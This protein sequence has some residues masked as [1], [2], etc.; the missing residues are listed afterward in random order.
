MYIETMGKVLSQTLHENGDLAVIVP[1]PMNSKAKKLVDD[2]LLKWMKEA[3][4]L[5]RVGAVHV[6][7]PDMPTTKTL[8][9]RELRK[10]WERVLRDIGIFSPQVKRILV[11]GETKVLRVCVPGLGAEIGDAHGTIFKLEN[12]LEL[13]PTF[14]LKDWELKH[15][16]P[17][18]ERDILRLLKLTRPEAPLPYLNEITPG[19]K[20]R[21]VIDLETTG[22][23]HEDIIT[24]VGI[25]WSDTERAIY[26]NHESTKSLYEL[27]R[28]LPELADEFWFHNSQFDLSFMGAEF[29][30]RTFGKIHDTMIR[31]KSRGELVNSLKHL[32]NVYTARPGNYAW[33]VPGTEHRYDDPAYIAEDLDVTWRLAKIFDKDGSREVVKL[34]EEAAVMAC[35]QTIRGSAIDLPVLDNLVSEGRT[36]IDRAYPELCTKYGCN[37]NSNDE[38]IESLKDQGYSFVTYTKTGKESITT[39]VLEGQGLY[40]IVEYRKAQKLDS[41]FVAKIRSLIRKD[42]LLPHIQTM[43]GART[44]RSTMRDFNHQQAGRK[45]PVKKLL[46]SRFKN[47]KIAAVDLAQAEL[48]AACLLADDDVMAEWL[49]SVDAHRVNAANAFQVAFEEV[50]DDQRTAAKTVVF[51]LVYGGGAQTD[52][53]KRVEEYLRGKFKKLFKWLDSVGY[54][55]MRE[56]SVTDYWGKTCG[57]LDLLDYRGKGGVRRAGINS[58]IQGL[59]SHFAI[60]ITVRIWKL[61]RELGLQSLVLFGVHDS[62]VMDVHPDEEE[63]VTQ[64]VRQAFRDLLTMTSLQKLRL[65]GKLAIEG[66][67]QFGS[68]W[69]DTKNGEKILCSTLM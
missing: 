47:G 6:I 2:F 20:K 3:G 51:R 24:A 68:S 29:R 10:G 19:K 7:L 48:R 41:S 39:E 22:L 63:K 25:Q 5:N 36:Y 33:H 14:E 32:G 31:S 55:A 21:I 52:G 50:T 61:F 49:M 34:M 58:P 9:L 18:M 38:L 66:E 62:I 37:I 11:L 64:V 43:M 35:E 59:A 45:G 12:G 26:T 44:G 65:S 67:L 60:W 42:G 40:D 53:Q 4:I 8:P 13:V 30:Q 17:W 46:I 54:K 15:V 28:E 56:N 16:R 23:T 69:A 1:T 27:I 57:L